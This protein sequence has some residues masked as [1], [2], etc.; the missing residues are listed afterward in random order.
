MLIFNPLPQFSRLGFQCPVLF[1]LLGFL[2][3]H[4]MNSL[5]SVCQKHVF[6]CILTYTDQICRSKMQGTHIQSDN[7]MTVH[8]TLHTR[9]DYAIQSTVGVI[10]KEGGMCGC[11]LDSE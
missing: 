1:G 11:G 9:R 5:A 7:I 6:L 8:R 3:L 2:S 10:R 4:S